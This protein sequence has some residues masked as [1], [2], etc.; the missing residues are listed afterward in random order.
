MTHRVADELVSRLIEAGGNRIYGIE[1]G[2][3][4]KGNS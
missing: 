4:Y 2:L 1:T 3:T